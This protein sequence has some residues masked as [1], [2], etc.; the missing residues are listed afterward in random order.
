MARASSGIACGE[1][2]RHMVRQWGG[3]RGS[4]R[5]SGAAS[6]FV[7]APIH[8]QMVAANSS[9]PMA[10]CLG[11]WDARGME[12]SLTTSEGNAESLYMQGVG[13]RRPGL[14]G[15]VGS[16]NGLLLGA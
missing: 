4:C 7:F 3:L 16:R 13:R 6:L 11:P 14:R 2:V 12:E 10:A 1:G 9:S 8:A 15:R 5:E